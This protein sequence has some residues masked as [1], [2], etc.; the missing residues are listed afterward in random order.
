MGSSIKGISGVFIIAV[1]GYS[2]VKTCSSNRAIFILPVYITDSCKQFVCK[3]IHRVPYQAIH[4]A[5]SVCV[6]IS[7]RRGIITGVG[8]A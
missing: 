8:E 6:V 1:I 7:K 2:H 5:A 4:I 3:P